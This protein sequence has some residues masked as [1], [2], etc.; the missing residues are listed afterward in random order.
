MQEQCR[1]MAQSLQELLEQVLIKLDSQISTTEHLLRALSRV[2]G[3]EGK[4]GNL[5]FIMNLPPIFD[6]EGNVPP[7]HPQAHSPLEIQR[8][9]R[10]T[11]VDLE[12][13]IQEVAFEAESKKF[14]LLLERC[15]TIEEL[16][17]MITDFSK[18]NHNQDFEMFVWERIALHVS[19][20]TKKGFSAVD[21]KHK[22]QQISNPRPFSTDL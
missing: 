16:H 6:R 13:L 3:L 15:N 4:L 1:L 12:K 20:Q 9:I 18:F 19:K 14:G 22:Y 5:E 8:V 21:C 7:K 11:Q 10:W 17:S 2:K